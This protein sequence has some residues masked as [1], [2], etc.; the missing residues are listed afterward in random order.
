MTDSIAILRRRAN[1]Q[2]QALLDELANSR[3]QYS[4]LSLR[5]P[6][7]EGIEK[8]EADLNKL[9]E[10]IELLENRI[11]SRSAEFKTT[12]QP[13]TLDAVQKLIPNDATLIEYVAYRP[14]AAKTKKYSSPH[15]AVYILFNRGEP[16]F[17]DLG[18]MATIN[19]AISEMRKIL[20]NRQSSIDKEVKP[21]ARMLDELVMRP[22]RKLIGDKRRLLIAPDGELNLIPFDALVDENGKYMTES[23]EISYLT[24][25]R[26]L[27]RLQNGITNQ[28][29][30]M[31]L[32]NP[33]FGDK[34]DTADQRRIKLAL[35]TREE[36]EAEAGALDFSRFYFS[37]LPA[38][39][40]EA[41]LLS[42][43][44]PQA[45]IY[46]QAQASKAKLEKVNAPEF[47]HIATHGFFIDEDLFKDDA[48]KVAA[49][50][51]LIQEQDS[52]GR[53]LSLGQRSVKLINPLL[54]SGLGLAGANL[55][56]DNN[57]GILTALE[58]TGLNLWGTKLV[59]L[60][61]CDTG[62]GEVKNGDGVYGLRRALVLAGSETQMMSL[63]PVSDNGTRELMTSY[64]GN[65]KAG[66]GR[67]AALRDVQLKMI[68]D[69]K[70]A[71]PFYWASFIQSGEWANLA[72]QR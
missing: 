58:A 65:L 5:G 28:Q 47:L 20:P 33:D 6:G 60:S 46:T 21:A 22:V 14:F 32:A 18:E 26:D 13:I 23:Y 25:G 41:Q 57:D 69:P 53:D 45:H 55:K 71:H 63:W 11:S 37:P 68:A 70:R 12:I 44:Y 48:D 66:M 62:V 27:L 67:S 42:E 9:A 24:S 43:L 52:S 1:P 36:T 54:R 3:A 8:H 35:P 64:Y 39:A 50:R 17:A 40:K 38:T 30:P 4:V 15:Y 59:V 61:A 29:P 19:K 49:K 7:K 72:G 2:D 31:V 16:L 56:N 51:I 10:K 34:Q